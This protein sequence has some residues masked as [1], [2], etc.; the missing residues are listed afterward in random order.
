MFNFFTVGEVDNGDLYNPTATAVNQTSQTEGKGT[1]VYQG[2]VPAT[3]SNT[4]GFS[5][6][7]V[8]VHPCLTQSHELRLITWS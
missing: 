7:V 3:E 2:R 1:Y 8:P 6:R 4:Y 5:V